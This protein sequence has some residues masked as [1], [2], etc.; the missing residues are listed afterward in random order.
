M[1]V[2]LNLSVVE[3]VV[4]DVVDWTS[5]ELAV[6][7]DLDLVVGSGLEDLSADVAAETGGGVSEVT[8]RRTVVKG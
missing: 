5:S 4:G 7:S 8:R 3:S 6:C 2:A 1:E